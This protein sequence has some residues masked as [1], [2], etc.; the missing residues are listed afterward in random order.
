MG[1]ET[2]PS[3]L[4]NKMTTFYAGFDSACPMS[5]VGAIFCVPKYIGMWDYDFM[6]LGLAPCKLLKIKHVYKKIDS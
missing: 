3:L 4:L 6:N 1:R 5:R 2:G